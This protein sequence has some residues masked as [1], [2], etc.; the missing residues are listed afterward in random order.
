MI[1]VKPFDRLGKFR[2]EWLNARYHFSFGHSMS[3]AAQSTIPCRP[4]Y[5]VASR[6]C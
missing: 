5:G 4:W 6:P 2:I 3:L 1:V